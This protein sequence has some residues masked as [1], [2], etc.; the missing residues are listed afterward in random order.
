M[1]TR[2]HEEDTLCGPTATAMRIQRTLLAV[3]SIYPIMLDEPRPG[4]K[5]IETRFTVNHI[6]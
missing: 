2:A 3:R 1:P 5:P 4:A 6:V